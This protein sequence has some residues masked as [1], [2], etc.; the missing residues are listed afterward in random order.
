[1]WYYVASLQFSWRECPNVA[2]PRCS[3]S[4]INT[5]TLCPKLKN[6]NTGRR[7]FIVSDWLWYNAK[8]NM[9]FRLW[10]HK[11]YPIPRP[12]DWALLVCSWIKMTARYQECTVF[13]ILR[14]AACFVDTLATVGRLLNE[15]GL[16]QW[17]KAADIQMGF[18]S[19]Q[20]S[21][22]VGEPK[23]WFLQVILHY[24]ICHKIFVIFFK[25]HFGQAIFQWPLL[26]LI[27]RLQTFSFFSCS[28]L[29]T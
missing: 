22:P 29:M 3:T 14:Y 23:S 13:R 10:M 25:E 26:L 21:K 16:L 1:M 17:W 6:R 11:R 15:T 12:T 2:R 24:G 28:E 5:R 18:V 20:V 27:Y 9:L 8:C 4:W 19:S 7:Q